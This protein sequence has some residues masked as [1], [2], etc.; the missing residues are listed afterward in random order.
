MQDTL[1]FVLF[2]NTLE[3]HI[4]KSIVLLTTLTCRVVRLSLEQQQHNTWIFFKWS[5]LRQKQFAKTN[6]WT[7]EKNKNKK[8]KKI[9]GPCR[10]CTCIH[11]HG[12]PDAVAHNWKHKRQ[13]RVKF[14]F[15]SRIQFFLDKSLSRKSRWHRK[16]RQT[17]SQR[18]ILECVEIPNQYSNN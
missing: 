2:I 3:Q 5:F 10:I 6:K 4:T 11:A 16:K 15:K 8:K 17:H 18:N 1:F 12:S 13:T 9:N 7:Q 14:K